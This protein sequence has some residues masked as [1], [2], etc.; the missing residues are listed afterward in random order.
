MPDISRR[1]RRVSFPG[2]GILRISNQRLEEENEGV[3]EGKNNM[4]SVS[5]RPMNGNSVSRREPPSPHLYG[6]PSLLISRRGSVSSD[7]S[8]PYTTGG[9]TSPSAIHQGRRLSGHSVL[10]EATSGMSG[11]TDDESGAEG[12]LPLPL[13]S[14]PQS[15]ESSSANYKNI[16]AALFPRIESPDGSERSATSAKQPS[17]AEMDTDTQPPGESN[18]EV[19]PKAPPPLLLRSHS[20]TGGNC[21]L[22][23]VTALAVSSPEAAGRAPSELTSKTDV[24]ASPDRMVG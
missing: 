17:V 9:C 12:A 23:V 4:R 21:P 2:G 16:A 6:D 14:R 18:C 15:S 8:D 11:L 10:S 22:Q 1:V 3:S 5:N 19:R 24:C 20:W 7:T 13:S